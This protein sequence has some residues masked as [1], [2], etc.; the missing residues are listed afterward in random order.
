MTDLE[1]LERLQE[2]AKA[3]ARPLQIAGGV[4]TLASCLALTG[5]LILLQWAMADVAEVKLSAFGGVLGSLA[6]VPVSFNWL[7]KKRLA[8]KRLEWIDELARTEGVRRE[9]LLESFTL[10]SW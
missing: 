9:M 10:D 4:V 5:L 7:I 8:I 2:R 1:A 6:I 3:L